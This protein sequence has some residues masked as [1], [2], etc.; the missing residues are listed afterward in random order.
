MTCAQ[1]SARRSHFWHPTYQRRQTTGGGDFEATLG[2]AGPQHAID[3]QRLRL[4]S[5]SLL[6]Q[7]LT[8]EIPLD[9]L[10]RR[11]RN[12]QGIGCRQA[13]QP[14]RNMPGLPQCQRFVVRPHVQILH[15]GQPRMQSQLHGDALPG[16]QG[17]PQDERVHGLQNAET[18]P[19]GPLGIV[20]VRHRIAKIDQ[21]TITESSRQESRQSGASPRHRLDD[22]RARPPAGLPG[23]GALPGWESPADRSTA[24]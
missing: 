9:E 8:R 10:I 5:E 16:G 22:R 14:L 7:R 19:D 21:D 11:C 2:P 23:P 15:H 6:S 12:H 20:F 3:R 13:L 1:R 17:Q 4:A 18:G 24:R